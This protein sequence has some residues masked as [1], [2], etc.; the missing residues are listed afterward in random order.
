MRLELG[1]QHILLKILSRAVRFHYKLYTPQNNRLPRVMLNVLMCY[2]NLGGSSIKT[3]SWLA[4]YTSLL[5]HFGS[6]FEEIQLLFRTKRLIIRI[7]DG[8]RTPGLNRPYSR[9]QPNIHLPGSTSG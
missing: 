1:R 2:S 6:S 5:N 8:K 9:T 7:L 3:K 4:N